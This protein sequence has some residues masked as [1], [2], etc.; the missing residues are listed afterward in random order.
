[1]TTWRPDSSQAVHCRME[2]YGQVDE[3]PVVPDSDRKC[4]CAECNPSG[5]QVDSIHLPCLCL[6]STSSVMATVTI[7]IWYMNCRFFIYFGLHFWLRVVII[8][9]TSRK[10]VGYANMSGYIKADSLA[11][12]EWRTVL[13]RRITSVRLTATVS[14]TF[15]CSWC[16]FLFSGISE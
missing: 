13:S 9:L 8:W 11:C 16:M 15:L 7:S 12:F 1:M 2:W 10:N 5:S 14:W 4:V 3:F 6:S